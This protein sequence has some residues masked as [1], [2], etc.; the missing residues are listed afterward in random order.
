[1]MIHHIAA[2]AYPF[3]KVGGL[4][5]VVGS[6][7]NALA[8]QGSPSTV[9]IPYYDIPSLNEAHLTQAWGFSFPSAFGTLSAEVFTLRQSKEGRASFFA[10]KVSTWT[11]RK[12]IYIDPESG[13]G[14]WDEFQRTLV[15]QLAAL[16]A[17]HSFNQ[18]HEYSIQEQ[19]FHCHD[20]HTALIPFLIEH[21]QEF[22]HFKGIPTVL[23]LHNGQYHGTTDLSKVSLLP[24][25]D[26]SKQGLLEW[27]QALNP[28]ACGIKCAWHVTT[29]SPSY[30][31][32][33]KQSSNGL[34]GLMLM[35]DSKI[36]G[37]LNGIDST[38][39][40][41]TNDP[42]LA[43]PLKFGRK[44]SLKRS[45]ALNRQALDEHYTLDLNLPIVAFIGRLVWEKGADMLPSVIHSIRNEGI[46]LNFILLGTGNPEIQ[47]QLTA[48][49]TDSKPTYIDTRLEY[50]EA[51]A[52]QIYAGCDFIFMPSRVEPCGLNQMYAMA[53]GAIPVVSHVGGLKD[54]VHSLPDKLPGRLPS[55][56]RTPSKQVDQTKN[57]TS[58]IPSQNPNGHGFVIDDFSVQ[59]I[60]GVLRQAVD[61]WH[62]E[63]QRFAWMK[64]NHHVDFS[65]ARS[66]KT[67]QSVY[68]NL[69][70]KRIGA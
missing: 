17:I 5:D 62:Q 58:T 40:D 67:T 11:D 61:F 65:W 24:A 43:A 46:P 38:V 66:A 68:E 9:W 26:P 36:T 48:L 14:Y 55:K 69:Q 25:F 35:E 39:W 16:H 41:S 63:E 19:I 57:V 30:A 64:A 21:C 23:T 2:E 12:G 45:K 18:R 49:N 22:A 33:L 6:L 50:N 59:N 7:P 56:K 70:R 4:G 10:I 20:H 44:D 3:A 13:H 31:E 54:T 52:H 29:V 32:E 1:M 27:D 60:V 42:H 53:Y 28:L 8:E 47:H 37:I 15:F 34:E 51:L